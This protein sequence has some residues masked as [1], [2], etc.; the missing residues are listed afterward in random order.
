[1]VTDEERR[2]RDIVVIGASAGG[3]E[4]LI[5]LAGGLPPT[6]RAAVFIVLHMP[7]GAST[8]LPQILDR[9]GT[10]PARQAAE[11]APIAPGTITIAP[12]DH[13]LVLDD[14]LVRALRGP[15]VNGHRPAVDVLFHSAAR[16]HGARVVGIV[17]TGSLYD[18]TLGLR[19]IKRHGGAAIV[20]SGAAHVGMPTSA[21]A[22]VD[23]DAVVPLDEIPKALTMFVGTNGEDV[24]PDETVPGSDLEAGFDISSVHESPSGPSIFRCPECGGAMWELEDGALSGYACHVGHTY[25]ADSML[26][27][28]DGEVE[29]ALWTAVRLLE[30]KAEL[31][32]RLS[33]RVGR[34]GNVRSSERFEERAKEAERQAQLIR[35]VLEEPEL[36]P[37]A[38]AG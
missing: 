6:L 15:K 24:T 14:G 9:Q 10:L 21:M 7:E 19:A 5:R 4:A 11:S 20:Q 33:Q 26:E 27:A 16:S 28:T 35:S 38:E 1:M 36:E 12:P 25:S 17:L 8:S 22:N 30:E 37:E 31:V 18:G 13:H 32:S 29:R 2:R 34:G 3:V 23:V